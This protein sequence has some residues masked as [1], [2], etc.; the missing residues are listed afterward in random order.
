MPKFRSISAIINPLPNESSV[1]CKKTGFLQKPGIYKLGI[2]QK[3]WNLQTR[4][5][6]KNREF[7]NSGFCK[8]TGIYK[9][10]ILQ[11]TGNLQTRDFAKN[12]VLLKNTGFF[13]KTG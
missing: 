10:G 7:T 2:L 8:K 6:A 11:K 4:D 5:F 1:F 13:A 3:T 9:L 12:R